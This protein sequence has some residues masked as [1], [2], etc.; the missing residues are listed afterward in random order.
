MGNS[1]LDTLRRRCAVGAFFPRWRSVE[2]ATR[3]EIHAFSLG[4]TLTRSCNFGTFTS[5]AA[6]RREKIR[7]E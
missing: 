6:R 3:A 7:T 4:K 1:A 2:K 5:P